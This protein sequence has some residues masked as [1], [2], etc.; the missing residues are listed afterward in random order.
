MLV[1]TRK[2]G[3]EI[4][5]NEDIVITLVSCGGGRAQVAVKAPHHVSIDR[6]EI[7]QLK[8][9]FLA[10]NREPRLNRFALLR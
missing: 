10:F 8:K 9:Q 2:P 5:I 6:G 1:L 4:V 3:E 7:H